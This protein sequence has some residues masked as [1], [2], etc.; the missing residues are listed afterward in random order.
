MHPWE[1]DFEDTD[2]DSE[3]IT[4][5]VLTARRNEIKKPSLFNDSLHTIS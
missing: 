4:T 3:K 1:Y 2:D 5:T